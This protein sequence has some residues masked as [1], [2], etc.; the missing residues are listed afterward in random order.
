[1]T[2]KPFRPKPQSSILPKLLLLLAIPIV[3]ILVVVFVLP[4]FRGQEVRVYQADFVAAGHKFVQSLADDDIRTAYD[5]LMP[6][7]RDNT[8]AET[9]ERQ[10]LDAAKPLGAFQ[11]F[12]DPQWGRVVNKQA[13]DNYVLPV[14]YQSGTLNVTLTLSRV[15]IGSSSGPSE[16]RIKSYQFQRQ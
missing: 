7:L 13:P 5:L 11:S 9:L 14:K 4:H 8:A 6:D 1:M 16:T 2:N 3:T 12:G 10:Y 15:R